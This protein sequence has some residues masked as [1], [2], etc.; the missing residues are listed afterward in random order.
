MEIEQAGI[1]S[2]WNKE[3]NN[4]NNIK[5]GTGLMHSAMWLVVNSM[6]SFQAYANWYEIF[7][8][9]VTCLCS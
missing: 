5:Y 7:N 9:F 6:K 2:A 3:Y 1:G 8:S 4:T